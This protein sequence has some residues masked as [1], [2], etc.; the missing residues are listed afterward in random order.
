MQQE[1]KRNFHPDELAERARRHAQQ[2]RQSLQVAAR[3]AELFPQVLRSIKKSAGN[4]G[5]QGDREALT[6]PDYLAKLDQYIAVLGE[7]L[8][9]RVQFETHRMMIQA[10]QSENAF[11]KAFSRL[12]IQDK[13]RFAAQD[14]RET[15]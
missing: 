10:Y 9:A 3:L 5:A 15:P 14:R 4:K 11:Q 8:E 2:S 7:G 6:H 12:K 13:R 1:R